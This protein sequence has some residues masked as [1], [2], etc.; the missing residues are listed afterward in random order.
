MGDFNLDLLQCHERSLCQD[1]LDLMLSKSYA[2]TITKPTRITESTATLIDNIFVSGTSNV[3]SG[4]IVNDIS[5]HF[6]VYTLVSNV[7]CN[8]S[9]KTNQSAGSRD[10]SEPNL[11]RL[12]E[13][14]DSAD[15]FAVYNNND[16]NVSF[17]N[18]MDIIMNNL[19]SSIPIRQRTSNYKK[20]S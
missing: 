2:P 9:S 12:K 8:S 16:V 7:I 20:M 19:N 14:L 1:F 13:A 5:D 3:Q 15:W 11:S 17:N 10:F 6:P 4:I 18:F